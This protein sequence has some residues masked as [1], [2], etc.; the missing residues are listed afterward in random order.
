MIKNSAKPRTG[1]DVYSIRVNL[2]YESKGRW[3]ASPKLQMHTFEVI[4]KMKKA[5]GGPAS[6]VAEAVIAYD[7]QPTAYNLAKTGNSLISEMT[8]VCEQRLGAPVK[9]ITKLMITQSYM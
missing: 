5:N 7:K 3:V 9:G 6:W 1:N 2:Y 4:V 8:K